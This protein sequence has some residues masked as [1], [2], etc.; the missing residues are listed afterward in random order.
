MTDTNDALFVVRL[1]AG[2]KTVPVEDIP[3]L[4]AMAKSP[5]YD[6][7]KASEHEAV[8]FQLN[9]INEEGPLNAAVRS[10][11]VEALNNFTLHRIGQPFIGR[12]KD[13]VLTVRALRGYVESING[14]LEVVEATKPIPEP[15]TDTATPAPVAVDGGHAKRRTKKLSIETVALDYMRKE[16]E[17]G[18]FESAAK[19]HKHLIKTAG[20]ADSPFEMG[21]GN[22]G[23]KLFCPAASSFYDLGTLGKLWPKIRAK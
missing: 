16:Y 5:G 12:L 3:T 2:E 6:H 13:A 19:F 10:G 4:I 20:V 22:N 23:R 1:P 18:Q 8:I 15:A 9:V 14:G 21:T 11:E 7:E 17:A